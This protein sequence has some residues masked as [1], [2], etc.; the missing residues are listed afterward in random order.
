M[1]DRK[2]CSR[3]EYN[4]I[5]DNIYV[6]T[7]QCCQTH[8]DESLKVLGLTADL[9]L[10]ENRIDEPFGVE[11]YLWL[12][13]IDLTAPS[14]DQFVIGVQFLKTLVSLNRKVYVHCQMGHGRAPTIVAA[15]LISQGRSVSEAIAFIK[16]RRP[17]IHLEDV[18]VVA[19]QE[20]AVAQRARVE[21]SA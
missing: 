1:E 20:Y 16:E 21:A 12:P 18:Q 13:V 8:F 10:E 2:L 4:Q 14:P 3:L 17:V 19:L 9:S 6:G 15:Y 5:T 11:F 7:N